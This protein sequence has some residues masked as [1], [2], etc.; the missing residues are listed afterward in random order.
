MSGH[1]LEGR[2]LIHTGIMLSTIL[3]DAI[4]SLAKHQNL[5]RIVSWNNSWKL[6]CGWYNSWTSQGWIDKHHSYWLIQ[7]GGGVGLGRDKRSSWND[8]YPYPM[9]NER[10]IAR[11][12]WQRLKCTGTGD[13]DNNCQLALFSIRSASS[14]TTTFRQSAIRDYQRGKIERMREI[15]WKV[16]GDIIASTREQVIG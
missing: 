14:A 9:H 15:R 4:A 11:I 2:I 8:L 3:D 1:L 16:K 13:F 6:C 10:H 12:F 5:Q 7:K